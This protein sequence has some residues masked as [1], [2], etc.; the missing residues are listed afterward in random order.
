MSFYYF[1]GSSVC[2]FPYNQLLQFNRNIIEYKYRLWIC[3]ANP[4]AKE[5]IT[6]RIDSRTPDSEIL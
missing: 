4:V 1:M 6:E 5:Y 3:V 2:V